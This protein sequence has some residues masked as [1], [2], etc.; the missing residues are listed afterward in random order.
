MYR[1]Q[2]IPLTACLAPQGHYTE[3]AFPTNMVGAR[4]F[5][6]PTPC[7]QGRCAI[8]AALRPDYHWFLTTSWG[9]RQG[10]DTTWLPF[11][12]VLP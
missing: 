5:E 3:I 2:K 8:Q 10:E 1:L 4:G 9:L 6:P 7:A 11:S 12:V